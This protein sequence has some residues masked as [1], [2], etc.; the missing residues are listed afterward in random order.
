[1][2]YAV[3]IPHASVLAII[4]ECAFLKHMYK[5]EKHN[6]SKGSTECSYKSF[7]IMYCVTSF[8]QYMTDFI[9]CLGQCLPIKRVA[10][11]TLLF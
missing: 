3:A 2:A 1:M 9:E 11:A 4:S 7:Y 8:I 6:P 10:A 5:H